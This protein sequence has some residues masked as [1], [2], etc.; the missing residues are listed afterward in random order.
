MIHNSFGIEEQL[1]TGC[2]PQ[3]GSKLK[4]PKL[5]TW[6]F[7]DGVAG[8]NPRIDRNSRKDRGLTRDKSIK[9]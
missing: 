5:K 7:R 4:V 2:D 1:W 8:K 6:M 3:I 9:Y